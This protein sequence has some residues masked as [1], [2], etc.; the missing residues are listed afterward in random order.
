MRLTTILT[1]ALS[2]FSTVLA[3]QDQD[4]SPTPTA[5]PL[6]LNPLYGLYPKGSS[7]LLE[8]DIGRSKDLRGRTLGHLVLRAPNCSAGYVATCPETENNCCPSDYPVCCPDPATVCCRSGAFCVGLKTCCTTGQ[9]GC[10]EACCDSDQTCCGTTCC[11]AGYSCT[12]GT[13]VNSFLSSQSVASVASVSSVST[14]SVL[15]VLS[16]QSAGNGNTTPNGNPGTI[17]NG[18]SSS[19]TS[20]RT[21][22]SSTSTSPAGAGTN[23]NP[24]RKDNTAAIVGGAVGGVAG[25]L[26]IGLLVFF[27]LR[28]NKKHKELDAAVN[29]GQPNA[30]TY[31]NQQPG[32]PTASSYPNSPP[33]SGQPLMQQSTGNPSFAGAAGIGAGAGYFNQHPGN[34]PTPA[35]QAYA[36][37]AAYSGASFHAPTPSNGGYNP[38]NP[39]AY[40][41]ATDAYGR[42]MS[43]ASGGAPAAPLPMWVQ[44][45]GDAPGGPTPTMND[46]QAYGSNPTSFYGSPSQPGY[47][48]PHQ[49]NY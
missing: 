3:D 33:H 16:V 42:P 23:T 14:Q 40:G 15:S 17:A 13:C 49:S 9:I 7:P 24:D 30:Y 8:G 1:I 45:P 4:A 5:E 22:G 48:H 6:E 34:A 29:N 36:P 38:T 37:S 44:R 25:L 32:P 10:G 28:R 11:D 18:G 35:S 12:A 39:A 19:S 47:Q 46:P 2:V 26:L 31:N 20:R 21:S 41:G 43:A 27:L